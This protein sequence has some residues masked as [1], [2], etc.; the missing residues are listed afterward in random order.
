MSP[1]REVVTAAPR[2]AG[3]R[4]VTSRSAI[5]H[6]ALDLFSDRGFDS[7]T[8]DGIATAA[9]IGRRTVFRYY[10]SKNDIPWG[11]FDEQLQRMRAT[12]AA[13]PPDVPGDDGGPPPCWTST[14][15]T[16]RSSTGTAGACAASSTRSPCRPTPRC[17]TPPGAT[18]S[19]TTSPADWTCRATPCCRRRSA[20]QP[21]RGPRRLRAVARPR[22]RRVARTSRHGVPGT[23]ERT[24]RSR[25]RRT[26][27]SVVAGSRRGPPT[28]ST[29]GAGTGRCPART[30]GISPAGPRAVQVRRAGRAMRAGSS[31][32]GCVP[33]ILSPWVVDPVGCDP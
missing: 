2:R 1:R 24:R 12:F 15:C 19:P 22:R 30:G 17:A 8:V 6:I 14:S 4:P 10:A 33:G 21:R 23:G 11:A 16:P 18:S 20:R 29:A 3:R 13:L 26:A 5:E 9:G 25:I 31:V 32:R 27:P 28:M 7:T